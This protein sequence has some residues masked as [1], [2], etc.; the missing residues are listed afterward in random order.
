MAR[1]FIPDRLRS[2]R[3]IRLDGVSDRVGLQGLGLLRSP[4]GIN[5]LATGFTYIIERGLFGVERWQPTV[6]HWVVY[7]L[8]GRN[9]TDRSPQILT[10]PMLAGF[11]VKR[12]VEPVE[13]I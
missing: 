11:A 10:L 12:A 6:A 7:A 3:Q 13:G 9:C 1:G 4:S 8:S 2:S 5:P